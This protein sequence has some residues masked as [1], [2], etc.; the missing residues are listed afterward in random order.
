MFL[1]ILLTLPILLVFLWIAARCL[2][3]WGLPV[4]L[5]RVLTGGV[6]GKH[7]IHR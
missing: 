2:V 3:S 4:R 5:P 7:F 1:D 6:K